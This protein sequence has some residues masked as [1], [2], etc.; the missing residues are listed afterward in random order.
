MRE[1]IRRQP[2]LM[3]GFIDH[4]HARELER[5]GELLDRVPEVLRAVQ[6]DLT[7]GRR[8]ERGRPGMS[9]DQVLRALVIKQ[10]NGFTYEELAFHLVDSRCYR[11]FCGF[12]AFD[13]SPSRSTLQ[14]NIKRVSAE[15]LESVNRALM[16]VARDEG[17]ERGRKL[18]VDC[19]T[20]ESNIHPPTDSSLLWDVT[21]VLGRLMSAA[22]RFGVRFTDRRRSA[23]RRWREIVHAGKR[24]ARVRGYRKLVAATEETLAE[25]RRVA[26]LASRRRC[27]SSWSKGNESSI[28][29]GAGCSRESRCRRKKR[30]CRSSSRTRTSSSR[31]R[32][33]PYTVISSLSAPEPLVSSLIASFRRATR[34]TR[35]SPSR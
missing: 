21:R 15:T 5:M 34:R 25:A 22:G 14:E 13:P 28:R 12:G 16:G 35:R 3:Q 24:P 18:R 10:M 7:G 26:Q 23:K 17:I 2:S 1:I 31:V 20:T 33:T 6:G 8:A 11:V 27:V 29:R 19:T 4:D 9:A 30:W 32:R